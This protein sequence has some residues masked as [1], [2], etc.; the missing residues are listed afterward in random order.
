MSNEMRVGAAGSE[1]FVIAC[2]ATSLLGTI[3][4]LPWRVRI[5]VARQVISTTSPSN[6]SDDTQLPTWNGFST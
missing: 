1:K 4:R 2:L 5:F 3:T 6:F